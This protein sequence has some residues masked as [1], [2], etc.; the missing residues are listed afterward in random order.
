M[1]TAMERTRGKEIKWNFE[2]DDHLLERTSAQ[3][4]GRIIFTVSGKTKIKKKNEIHKVCFP[5]RVGAP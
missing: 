5:D 2:I 1:I 3:C 4:I